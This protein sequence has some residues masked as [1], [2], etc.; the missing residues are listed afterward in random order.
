M[1]GGM[2]LGQRIREFCPRRIW[3]GLAVVV[4][5]SAVSPNRLRAEQFPQICDEKA[6]F[7]LGIE[8]YPGAIRLHE[9]IVRDHPGDALAHYH[10]GFAY[11]MSGDHAG[12]LREYLAARQL[13]LRGWDFLLNLG[14]L[15]L[16]RDD[17]REA[18][19]VL[20]EAA[21]VEPRHAEIHF[22]L[23][24]AYQRSGEPQRAIAEISESL[25]LDPAQPDSENELAVLYA[26][27]GNLSPA[28]AIW[29]QL[30]RTDPDYQPAQRNLAILRT[31]A[32]DRSSRL[33]LSATIPQ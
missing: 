6:D 15:H 32:Y 20:K 31:M 12:E 17:P 30:L 1:S 25:R 33:M 5:L 13:G 26:E 3:A 16:D 2:R 14:L 18:I 7:A 28:R 24:L 11:G 27:T 29:T 19:A 23:G 21:G 10:L 8:D 4:L 9:K 22:N